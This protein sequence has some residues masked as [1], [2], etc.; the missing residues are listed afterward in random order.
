[1]LSI[2]FKLSTEHRKGKECFD[3]VRVA[4][5]GYVRVW[6]SEKLKSRLTPY[7]NSS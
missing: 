2:T 7:T 1:M 5:T 6:H 3:D 4:V